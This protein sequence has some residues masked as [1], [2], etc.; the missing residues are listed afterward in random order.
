MSIKSRYEWRLSVSRVETLK[1]VSARSWHTTGLSDKSKFY[2]AGI[3][4]F[5]PLTT[6][7][8]FDNRIIYRPPTQWL[9]V[10]LGAVCDEIGPRLSRCLWSTL[11]ALRPSFAIS[12]ARVTILSPKRKKAVL[13]R[14]ATPHTAT[15]MLEVP[16]SR[17][18]LDEDTSDKPGSSP[19]LQQRKRCARQIH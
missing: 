17:S 6:T 5:S 8:T 10:T 3:R 7:T 4:S 13:Q 1:V 19:S 16:S 18:S 9:V 11:D 12:T 2:T 14:P 15:I